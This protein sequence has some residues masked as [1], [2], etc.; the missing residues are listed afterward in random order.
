MPKS[1]KPSPRSSLA[2]TAAPDNALRC[3]SDTRSIYIE[4]PGPVILSY[5]L[6]ESGLSKALA[7]ISGQRYDFGASTPSL[8]QTTTLSEATAQSILR[9]RG[10]IR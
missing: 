10:I 2:P 4:I 3:W 8:A 6:T 9:R 7:L 1:S 5:P